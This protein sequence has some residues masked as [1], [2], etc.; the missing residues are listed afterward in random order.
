MNGL[1]GAIPAHLTERAEPPENKNSMGKDDFMKLL[2][3]QLQHQDPLN[4]MDHKEFGAQLA[5][6]ASLEKLTQIGSGI[7]KLEGGMGEEA[8]LQAL[9]M[10]G[11]RVQASG[12]EVSLIENQPVDITLN[13]E[14]GFKPLK[15]SIFAGDGK[16]IREMD[17][18]PMKDAKSV[19]WDGKSSEGQ[20]APSGK[21]LFR[22]AGV[23]QDGKAK[24]MQ[25]NVNGK[26]I[27]VEMVDKQPVLLVQTPTGQTKIEMGKVQNIGAD[28]GSGDKK[29][30]AVKAPGTAMAQ[31]AQTPKAEDGEST[32]PAKASD[33]PRSSV[34]D[35][36]HGWMEFKP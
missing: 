26:V 17:M 28:D 32:A 12:A 31:V 24:E 35:S 13:T 15:V 4:P 6:F 1:T 11:K 9:G 7:E 10:I 5:Q 23:G 2:M 14:G 19:T 34:M 27:G 30:P 20:S 3:A 22:V 25:M 29:A 33:W 16:L 36:G 21:Y 8:K 18:D